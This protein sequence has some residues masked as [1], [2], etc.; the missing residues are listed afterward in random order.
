MRAATQIGSAEQNS[1]LV[2]EIPRLQ[3]H[4]KNYFW[5]GEKVLVNDKGRGYMLETQSSPQHRYP[6]LISLSGLKGVAVP[7]RPTQHL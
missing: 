7:G 2:T 3:C 6:A 1:A 4:L 5:W